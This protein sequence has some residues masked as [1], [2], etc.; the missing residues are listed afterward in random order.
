MCVKWTVTMLQMPRLVLITL[1]A[2]IIDSGL[3]QQ[4]T[5]DSQDVTVASGSLVTFRCTVNNLGPTQKVVW[6]FVDHNV[7][8]SIGQDLQASSDKYNINSP[9]DATNQ[10][11]LIIYKVQLSDRGTYRCYVQGLM[12]SLYLNHHLSIS[13]SPTAPPPT[14]LDVTDCCVS[15]GV[16]TCAL[17]MCRTVTPIMQM[18]TIAGNSTCMENNLVKVLKCA[19]DGR[20][21]MGC[22]IRSGLSPKCQRLCDGWGEAEG[23]DFSECILSALALVQCFKVGQSTLPSPPTSVSAISIK[24]QIVVSWKPPLENADLVDHYKIQYRKQGQQHFKAINVSDI[25]EEYHIIPG[26]EQNSVVEIRV[27]AVSQYG[28]SQPSNLLEVM[29]REPVNVGQKFME[30]KDCCASK[31]VNANCLEFCDPTLLYYGGG[32]HLADK[33]LPCYTDIQPI[34]QCVLGQGNHTPCCDQMNIPSKCLPLCSGQYI[35]TWDLTACLQ[36]M[37]IISACVDEG[38]GVLPSSPKNTHIVPG[39]I[40][41]NAVTVAWSNPDDFALGQYYLVA[42]RQS[43]T[44]NLYWQTANVTLGTQYMITGLDA[45]TIYDI[46]V[47]TVNGKGSSLPEV[48]LVIVTDDEPV[49]SKPFNETECCKKKGVRTECL[50]LC[51]HE[52]RIKDINAITG[53][54]IACFD[55]IEEMVYCSSDGRNHSECCK[56]EGISSNCLGLC[57]LKPDEPL[58]VNF[59]SCL[60]YKDTLSK[61]FETGRAALPKSPEAITVMKRDVTSLTVRWSAPTGGPDIKF[62]SVQYISSQ[63]YKDWTNGRSSNWTQLS[64]T[65]DTFKTISNLT[66]DSIY[67]VRVYA[68]NDDGTSLSSSLLTASTLPNPLD[69]EGQINWEAVWQNRT[70]CCQSNNFSKTC[71]DKCVFSYDFETPECLP[72]VYNMMMCATDGRNHVPCCQAIPN[73][74]VS[75]EHFCSAQ[76]S[77]LDA[78]DTLC[79][80]LIPQ[81]I[82]CFTEGQGLIPPPPEQVRVTAYT[83]DT[84]TVEWA[85]PIANCNGTRCEYLVILMPENAEQLT[86]PG[87]KYIMVGSQLKFTLANLQSTSQYKVSVLA[88][89]SN[90][91]SLP[92]PF[93]TV[94]TRQ[95]GTNLIT[96]SQTPPGVVPVDTSLKLVCTGPPSSFKFAWIR[97]KQSISETSQY[98]SSLLKQDDEGLYTCKV[99][100]TGSDGMAHEIERSIFVNIKYKPDPVTIGVTR[101][102]LP[103]MNVDTLLYCQFRGFPD[104]VSWT[105]DSQALQ[106]DSYFVKQLLHNTNNGTTTSELQ[107]RDVVT[108]DFGNYTCKGTNSFGSG[109]ITEGFDNDF[110]GPTLPPSNTTKSTHVSDCCSARNVSEECRDQICTYAVDINTIITNSNL[111]HCL[112]FFEDYIICGADGKDHSVC[113][114]TQ[115]VN[116]FCMP[117]CK[118]QVPAHEEKWELAL[119]VQ[120]SE[121]IIEC[122]IN[123]IQYSPSVPMDVKANVHEDSVVVHWTPPSLNADKVLKYEVYNYRQ[124]S[125]FMDPNQPQNA[126]MHSSRLKLDLPNIKKGDT[127]LGWVIAENHFGVSPRSNNY[128]VTVNGLVPPKP[129]NLRGVVAGNNVT[130]TWR[131]PPTSLAIKSYSIFYGDVSSTQSKKITVERSVYIL[132]GLSPGMSY[133]I[134]VAAVSEDGEGTRSDAIVVNIPGMAEIPMAQ[135]DGSTGTVV[136]V[137]LGIVFFIALAVLAVFFIKRYGHFKSKDL[138]NTNVAFENPQYSQGPKVTGLPGEDETE[139]NPY[140]YGRMREESE[141][142]HESSYQDIQPSMNTHGRTSF[143]NMTYDTNSGQGVDNPAMLKIDN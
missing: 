135:T 50:Q 80:K 47:S 28:A 20:N 140:G 143:D 106:K 1:L 31:S 16:E 8:I 89:N 43:G 72:D 24:T 141:L 134:S 57:T 70:H 4:I 45:A 98:S 2:C 102:V 63:Q 107:I 121:P 44:D 38:A 136:G 101:R 71:E 9:Q 51:S 126:G 83:S 116:D 117:F 128:T 113:C 34:Y 6:Q 133:S 132:M 49:A 139:N 131:K 84:I 92:A 112:A 94:V 104:V 11:N 127:Y 97:N 99:N 93:I 86:D 29:I 76:V 27:I 5:G 36:Y 138:G 40:T 60:L 22:C 33:L 67:M 118:G 55:A 123:A 122:A 130:L 105:K 32:P 35:L 74:P 73:F 66:A 119:C 100:Y 25:A 30:V 13:N 109:M 79:L 68:G 142:A 114:E 120:H 61:C 87:V 46:S 3:G 26:M 23:A 54:A 14:E 125:M 15:S 62:Y 52:F 124:P 42:W 129:T 75:C 77:K 58:T 18:A 95:P 37:P 59:L 96:I 10:W 21:H 115:G 12:E 48:I 19:Q 78:V 90:G 88:R 110:P 111:Y 103:G 81:I 91:E 85:T 82:A 64:K 56:R 7:T 53:T 39:S 108:E 69:K 65:A 41:H 137:V 17:P